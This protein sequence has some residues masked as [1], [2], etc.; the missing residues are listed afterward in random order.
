MHLQLQLLVLRICG[1]PPHDE[2]AVLP[3]C[4][5]ESSRPAW[6]CCGLAGVR[7]A[8]QQTGYRLAQ[9][10]LHHHGP[11]PRPGTPGCPD[12]QVVGAG[13]ATANK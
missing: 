6:Y 8:W 7:L 1:S 9:L 3:L 13:P 10:R 4:F 11:E 12:G 5:P 2:Q